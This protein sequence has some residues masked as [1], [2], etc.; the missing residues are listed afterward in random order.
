MKLILMG[1]GPF[2]VPAFDALADAGHEILLV[3][4]RPAP[5]VR[6]RK[7]PPPAPVRSLS[8]QH[9]WPIFDP[10]SINDA[11]AI[12]RLAALAPDLLVVC[13]YGEIL[14]AEALATAPLGG[15][16]LHGSLLPAYRG[17]APVQRALLAGETST[18]VAVIHMTPRLDGGPILATATTAIGPHETAGQLESRLAQLGVQPVL[19]AVE[20][21]AAWDRSSPLGRPQDPARVSRAPR[22]TKAEGRIDWTRSAAEIDRHVRGMQPWPGAYSEIAPAPGKPPLRV[23]I[24]RL[25]I[26]SQEQLGDESVPAMESSAGNSRSTTGLIPPGTLVDRRR[27]LVASGDGTL[28]IDSLQVAGRS[29]ISGEAFLKG[30]RLAPGARFESS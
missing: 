29:E 4:T 1:T 18:G 14:A 20:Q 6:S 13:D 21:L 3:I 17:A 28:Q 12:D 10:E 9:R 19:R 15:I 26:A 11:D 23:A 7:G 25:S 22:L 24:R 8:Q 5:K 2:A 16:N 30:Y 27:L